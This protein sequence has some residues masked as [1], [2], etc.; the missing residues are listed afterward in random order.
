MISLLPP[1]RCEK[2]ERITWCSDISFKEVYNTW[3]ELSVGIHIHLSGSGSKWGSKTD[4]VKACLLPVT[5]L[6]I[7]WLMSLL[8]TALIWLEDGNMHFFAPSFLM[9][10]WHEGSLFYLFIFS[11]GFIRFIKLQFI[12]IMTLKP[13]SMILHA[14]FNFWIIMNLKTTLHTVSLSLSHNEGKN[15][16]SAKSNVVW[17]I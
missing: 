11:F 15:N 2:R 5:M 1:L 4:L 6:K 3:R 14:F 13:I 16:F 8:K 10:Q 7:M 12:N 9:G 17:S